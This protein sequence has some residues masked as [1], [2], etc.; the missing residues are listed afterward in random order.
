[1]CTRMPLMFADL[2]LRLP[3]MP[4]RET[5]ISVYIFMDLTRSRVNTQIAFNSVIHRPTRDLAA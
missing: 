1:M 5:S 3:L 2:N 4:Q